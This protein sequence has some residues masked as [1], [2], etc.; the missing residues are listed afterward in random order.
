MPEGWSEVDGLL[1]FRGKAFVPD[2][3][4]LWPQL[5]ADAHGMSHEGTQKTLVHLRSSF[6]NAH[7]TRRV[8][9]YVKGCATCQHNKSEHLHP[10]GLAAASP[11]ALSN[12]E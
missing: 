7:M 2:S 10:A 8:R 9:D 3:S 4:E 11:C 6:Y 1:L 5:L 12:L